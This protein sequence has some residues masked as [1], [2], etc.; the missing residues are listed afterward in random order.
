MLRL[1]TFDPLDSRR[2]SKFAAILEPCEPKG[3]CGLFISC[4][5][6]VRRE[7]KR[8]YAR[9]KQANRLELGYVVVGFLF[10]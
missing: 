6:S 4:P 2:L 7:N 3:P 1:F 5:Y 10:E 9:G 8:E